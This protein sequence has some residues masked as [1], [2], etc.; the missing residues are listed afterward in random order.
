[1][2]ILVQAITIAAILGRWQGE[3]ICT[4]APGNG[5][6]HDEHVRYDF[7]AKDK[8]TVTNHAYK[9]VDGKYESMGDL[10]FTFN[11]AKQEWSSK[12]HTGRGDAIWSYKIDDDR[13]KAVLV[14]A[15]DTLVRNVT[16]RRVRH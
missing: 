5:A 11:A 15:P 13:M 16:A 14:V 6:C 7:V 1:M 12:F 4:K 8:D 2:K 3:S 10:D 9:L